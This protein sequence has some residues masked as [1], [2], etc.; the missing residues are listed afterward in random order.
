MASTKLTALLNPDAPESLE[1]LRVPDADDPDCDAV[2]DA[3]TW[4]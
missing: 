1:A 3:T 2:Y 4:A